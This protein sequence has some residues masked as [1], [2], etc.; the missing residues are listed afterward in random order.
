[1]IRTLKRKEVLSA[2]KEGVTTPE[3]VARFGISRHAVRRILLSEGVRAKRSPRLR[4]TKPLAVTVQRILELLNEVSD[5]PADPVGPEIVALSARMQRLSWYGEQPKCTRHDPLSWMLWQRLA[6][7]SGTLELFRPHSWR[8][9]A[10]DCNQS[11]DAIRL[12]A[13][14]LSRALQDLGGAAKVIHALAFPPALDA[15]QRETH[16]TWEPGSGTERW[17][18]HGAPGR[19]PLWERYLWIAGW[20]DLQRQG[21]EPGFKRPR[22]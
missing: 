21:I 22:G 4:T 2:A 5:D 9:V 18:E 13:Q 6:F 20:D 17:A 11:H 12:R 7:N 8:R 19:T 15:L 14:R 3:L 16:S 1:M 10:Q